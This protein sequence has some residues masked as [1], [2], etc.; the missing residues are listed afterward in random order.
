GYSVVGMIFGFLVIS[1]CVVLY[2]FDAGTP[3]RQLL[4][5]AIVVGAARFGMKG[6]LVVGFAAVPVSA[7]FEQQRA[8]WFHVGYRIE[9]VVFQASAGLLMA[10]VVGWVVARFDEERVLAEQRAEEAETL[11]DGLRRLADLP[12]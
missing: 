10:L 12:H 5:L 1:G 7:L 9:F 4:F 2:A 8:H 3:V 11:R 6:G